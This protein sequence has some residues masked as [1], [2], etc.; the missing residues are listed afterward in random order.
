LNRLDLPAFGRP[1]RAILN[2]DRQGLAGRAAA[3]PHLLSSRLDAVADRRQVHHDAVL[4]REVERRGAL[5]QEVE[6]TIRQARDLG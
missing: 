4:L 3:G 6:D 1:T 2:P 5:G